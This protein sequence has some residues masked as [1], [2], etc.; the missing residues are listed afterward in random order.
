MITHHTFLHNTVSIFPQHS[1]IKTKIHTKSCSQQTKLGLNVDFELGKALVQLAP[2][3]L[4][5]TYSAGC[6]NWCAV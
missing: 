4:R 3:H 5:S 1:N 6:R 2:F